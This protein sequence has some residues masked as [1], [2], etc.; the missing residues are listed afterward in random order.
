MARR[1]VCLLLALC[2][3]LLGGCD[4]A[5]ALPDTEPESDSDSAVDPGPVVEVPEE[6]LVFALAYSR[7][8]TLNP[9][10]AATK[11]NLQLS[12]L[13]YDSLTVITE[14]YV[15]QL[16]LAEEIAQPDA[17]HLMV[18]LREGAVFSD[19]SAVTANDV[20]KSFQAAQTSANYGVL[21]TN[22][23]SAKAD[24]KTGAV[25]F[26][27]ASA[28]VN[29]QACLTFPIVKASTLTDKAAEAPVGG[30]L[31]MTQPT[32]DGL[33]LVK[34]PHHPT[35]V[36]FTE[37]A[38][39]HLPNGTSRD[40]AL[41]SG[42]IAYYFDDLSEGEQPRVMGASQPVELNT[43]LLLGIN[44]AHEQLA[45]PEVR[46]ALSLM[47]D[48]T[49]MASVYGTGG[50]A[51]STLLPS[52]WLPMQ[53]CILPSAEQDVEQ[54]QS[55]LQQAEYPLTGK[56][57]PELRLIYWEGRKDR[58]VVAEH[59]RV[60][61]EACGVKVVPTPLNVTEYR[62][63]LADGEYELYLAEFRPGA[64]MSLRSLLLGGE[65]SYGVAEDSLAKEVYQR[66]LSGESTLQEFVDAFAVDTPYIPLC[67]WGGIAVYDRRLTVVTPTG[68]NPYYG[69]EQWQ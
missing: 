50:V 44:S 43:R 54:A 48:R 17:T 66:Y 56:D 14:G 27:L 67:G 26:T 19:G 11:V 41:A 61:A 8:D 62:Q 13:L 23:S 39:R 57:L 22:L 3:L 21:L 35:E 34:N 6:P 38:L 30:G 37:V 7:D 31:Y 42:Q 52:A 16:S 24:G 68:Y 45:L 46:Q 32:D 49:A 40:Y 28:D 69:I 12:Y 20:V 29:A 25:T 51:V 9:F 5:P 59:I 65:T 47:L 53:S 36:Q 10:S 60:Q 15:P 18:T 1:I 58:A 55:L 33:S 64:D 63:A 2:V 4:D